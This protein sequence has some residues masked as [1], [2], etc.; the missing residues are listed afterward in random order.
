MYGMLYTVR[1]FNTMISVLLTRAGISEDQTCR[2]KGNFGGSTSTWHL[3]PEGC[4]A[5]GFRRQLVGGPAR[6][7]HLLARSRPAGG[8]TERSRRPRLERV[9]VRELGA[10]AGLGQGSLKAERR[11]FDDQRVPA[12][13]AV[14]RHP[15]RHPRTSHLGDGDPNNRRRSLRIRSLTREGD[16]RGDVGLTRDPRR[17]EGGGPP[18]T[19]WAL[20]DDN[21]PTLRPLSTEGDVQGDVDHSCCSRM[22]SP[23][24]AACRPRSPGVTSS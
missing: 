20:K 14:Q 3:E 24:T 5:P 19:C 22:F 1:E 4:R 13:D 2:I 21:P 10:P 18:M 17:D 9:P 16:V 8:S 15:G 6:T 12:Q 7:C 23:N 11:A